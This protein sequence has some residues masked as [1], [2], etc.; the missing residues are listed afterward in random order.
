MVKPV[1]LYYLIL[2]FFFGCAEIGLDDKNSSSLPPSQPASAYP[3]TDIPIPPDFSRNDSKSWIYESGSGTVKVGRLFFA[4]Y[5]NQ[6]QVLTFYQNEMINKGWT[7]V[8]SIKTDKNQ[9]LHYEKEGWVSTIIL[10]SNI[11]STFIEIQ[12]GPK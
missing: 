3:F 8:N 9:V 6:D 10:N 1:S 2:F 7:L 5:K 12:A 4:G 11:V